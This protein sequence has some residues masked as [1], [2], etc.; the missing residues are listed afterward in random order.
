MAVPTV[1]YD[2]TKPAGTRKINLGDNDIRELKTQIR[3]IIAVDH[4]MISTQT[5]ATG[6]QHKKLTL[7]TQANLG[8]GASGAAL[9]GMQELPRT[10][11]LS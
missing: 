5:L 8:T 6:G 7:Q 4:E 10:H 1:Q 3:E 11:S 9:L 2:E